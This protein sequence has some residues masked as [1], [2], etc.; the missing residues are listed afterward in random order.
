MKSVLLAVSVF[1][2]SL[3][4]C[5]AFAESEIS[6]PATVYFQNASGGPVESVD[7]RFVAQAHQQ[8][9]VWGG[10]MR[11]VNDKGQNICEGVLG[12]YRS[13]YSFRKMKCLFS[14]KEFPD[15]ILSSKSKFGV[16]MHGLALVK[17]N[18]GLL[19][20]FV[21]IG[22]DNSHISDIRVPT[23]TIEEMYGTFPNWNVPN[24]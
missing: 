21:H 22:S 2:I 11:M 15:V 12:S 1:S 24:N 4:H 5:A 13:S 6:R 18:D 10:Q 8:G 16:P 7:V 9:P 14:D 19:G 3:F 20:V 23:T 17:V